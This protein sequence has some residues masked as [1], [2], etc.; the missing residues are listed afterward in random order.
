MASNLSSLIPSTEIFR[1]RG[2]RN[3]LCARVLISGARQMVAVAIGWQVYDLA[4]E[5]RSIEAS[6][7]L[8][9]MIGLTMF[10]PVLTLSLYGGQVA[11]RYN[12][13][14]ILVVATVVRIAVMLGLLVSTYLATA[15][16]L[17]TI[18]CLAGVLGMVNAFFPA[19]ASALYPNLIPLEDLHQA[20][21]WNS[22]AYQLAAIVGPAIGG[23]LFIGGLALVYG[24]AA[25]LAL[26]AL[27]FFIAI[28]APAQ[29]RKSRA[30]GWKMIKDGLSYVRDNKVVLGAISLDLIVVLFGGV[31]AL[32]PVFARD[33]LEVGATG[34][35]Y[36]RAA[37]AIGALLVAF[38]LALRPFTRQVGRNML[39]AIVIYGLA[40]LGFGLSKFFW[41]SMIMLAITGAADM[42]SVY[43]RASL[44]Q[45]AT[46]DAMRG[47]VSSISF[48]F[49]SAS[50]ELGEFE[51]GVATRFLGPVGAVI[52]GGAVALVTA[53]SWPFIFP[54]LSK[55]DHYN[56]IAAPE[57]K[58]T[59]EEE[60]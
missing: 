32:L 31:T 37:P 35:G 22:L 16:A 6:A 26:I 20:I 15:L 11:D 45:M 5:T 52:L 47:R 54:T 60:K 19:A 30:N 43:V 36:L 2:Y 44:I 33:I 24:C 46:P 56:D 41:L 59:L 49:I 55:A 12:R 58:I 1:H 39:I 38:Y 53:L 40:I 9:G 27:L 14:A 29:V 8:L 50:N 10:L 3:Y 21:A 25:G 48:I 42:I 18:F 28:A 17:K 13:K 34:L 57:N 4:R 51:S 7:F 23:F